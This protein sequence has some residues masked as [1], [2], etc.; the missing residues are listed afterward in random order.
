M[1][2][3]DLW[4]WAA[5]KRTEK[6]KNETY[7]AKNWWYVLLML[8]CINHLIADRRYRSPVQYTVEHQQNLLYRMCRLID[9]DN[10]ATLHTICHNSVL[11]CQTAVFQP[12]SQNQACFR[13]FW[14]QLH[15]IGWHI[16]SQRILP[17]QVHRDNT[18][19]AA[20]R[21]HDIK[22]PPGMLKHR[23]AACQKLRPILAYYFW[24]LLQIKLC[25]QLCHNF[26]PRNYI[27]KAGELTPPPTKDLS[28]PQ[29]A[30]YFFKGGTGGICCKL[31]ISSGFSLN[32][33][34]T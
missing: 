14:T 21:S 12:Q 34:C 22:R 19:A 33:S 3:Y 10:A 31:G 9:D 18:F 17:G 29:A 16:F 5:G 11:N 32:T 8:V 27:K 15:I 13:L 26:S 1:N 20:R 25:F 23:V 7:S 24:Y 4:K 6:D 30:I 2:N 28:K